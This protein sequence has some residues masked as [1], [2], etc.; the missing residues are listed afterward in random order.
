M[1]NLEMLQRKLYT[2]DA[3]AFLFIIDLIGQRECPNCPARKL[4]RARGGDYTCEGNILEWL[5]SEY[6]GGD[7]DSPCSHQAKWELP[8]N[9]TAKSYTRICSHCKRKA[10]IIGEGYDFCPNCGAEITGDK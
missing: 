8:E 4:C 10:Y 6:I 2:S 5:N 3:Y 9:H 7:K 1:K